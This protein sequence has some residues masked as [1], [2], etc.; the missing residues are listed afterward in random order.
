LGGSEYT[1]KAEGT[2]TAQDPSPTFPLLSALPA[3]S[4][5]SPLPWFLVDDEG[6]RLRLQFHC[7]ERQCTME[8]V[9]DG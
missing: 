9:Y 7:T 5:H 2:E 8:V 4:V 6:R 1:E 3:S